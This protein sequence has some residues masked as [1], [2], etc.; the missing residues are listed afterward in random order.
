MQDLLIVFMKRLIKPEILEGKSTS[1]MIKVDVFNE[2]HQF[3][4]KKI[5]CGKELSSTDHRESKKSCTYFNEKFVFFSHAIF[6]EKQT[7][8]SSLLR[9]HD[10]LLDSIGRLA[11]LIAHFISEREVCI[12][13]DRWRLYQLEDID[14]NWK[15]L[16]N[17][18]LLVQVI[19]WFCWK[20]L[21]QGYGKN[22]CQ[23]SNLW[24]SVFVLKNPTNWRLEIVVCPFFWNCFEIFVEFVLC[25]LG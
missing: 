4:V 24:Q 6:A 21:K 19:R 8:L 3:F 16:S 1:E 20:K 11:L 23:L 13:K 9:S 5:D 22:I 10:W 12:V 15:V 18:L 17:W 7:C 2:D 25:Y 14:K